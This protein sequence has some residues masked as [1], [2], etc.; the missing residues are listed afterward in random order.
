MQLCAT[1]TVLQVR[2]TTAIQHG[3]GWC[4]CYA[5]QTGATGIPGKQKTRDKRLNT[6]R[7]VGTEATVNFQINKRY[8]RPAGRRSTRRLIKLVVNH[9][10]WWRDGVITSDETTACVVPDFNQLTT[11]QKSGRIKKVELKLKPV[12]LLGVKKHGT[13]KKDEY[14]SSTAVTSSAVFFRE[15]TAA[16]AA[17]MPGKVLT[18][19]LGGKHANNNIPL[20]SCPSV[21]TRS[22]FGY[23]FN[24]YAWPSQVARVPGWHTKKRKI[25]LPST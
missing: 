8:F 23:R 10:E 3:I 11:Q 1:L 24:R 18:T 20:T 9:K 22:R 2:G 4:N 25:N 21:V 7:R 14:N 19:V 15:N 17:A 5:R 13:E 16:S 12:P 6:C